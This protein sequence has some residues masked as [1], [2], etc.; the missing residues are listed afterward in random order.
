MTLNDRELDAIERRWEA[1]SP[2]PWRAM[3]EGRDHMSGDSFIMTG[4]EAERGEDIYVIVGS[5]PAP[6]ADLDFIAGAHEDIPRLLA[7]I[8]RLRSR[9]CG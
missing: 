1:C 4:G 8:R 6:P 7:E 5:K 9:A 2:G 3:V